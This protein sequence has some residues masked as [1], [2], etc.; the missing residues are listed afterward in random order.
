MRK[1][2][3]WCE[4][5]KSSYKSHCIS[6]S[7]LI[8]CNSQRL[9]HSSPCSTRRKHSRDFLS[10]TSFPCRLSYLFQALVI[11]LHYVLS[12]GITSFKNTWYYINLILASNSA[13]LSIPIYHVKGRDLMCQV[14]SL[15]HKL[16]SYFLNVMSTSCHQMLN[17]SHTKTVPGTGF[18]I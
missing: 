14:E 10:F 2:Q 11:S 13:C 15:R 18:M 8:L 3:A 17:T 9:H 6:L 1:S 12:F 5:L 4:T 7:T 16:M